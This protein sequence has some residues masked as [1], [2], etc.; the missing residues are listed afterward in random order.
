LCDSEV[1]ALIAA[2]N[3]LAETNRTDFGITL[4]GDLAFEVS[5][6]GCPTLSDKFEIAIFIPKEY[7]E[8]LPLVWSDGCRI[9][10]DFEHINSDGSFCLAV[11]IEERST[12]DRSPTL[13]GFIDNLVVPFLYGYAYW[14]K[15]GAMPFDERSHGAA[16]L[17]EYYLDIYST[18][19]K[20]TV[21]KG[22]YGLVRFGYKPH[23]KC[24]CGSG[25]KVLRCHKA[26][27]TAIAKSPYRQKIAAELFV[28][29]DDIST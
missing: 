17:L 19:N 23:E 2:Y 16:G 4:S 25:K 12:F 10:K 18:S 29:L 13:L 20:V 22:V 8:K 24:P 14:E 27:S 15:F 21:L 11:P 9:R 6:S 7:P 28:I 26:E 1:A 3:G 5:A